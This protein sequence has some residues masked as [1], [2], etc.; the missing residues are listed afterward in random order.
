MLGR[1]VCVPFFLCQPGST[2]APPSCGSGRCHT[3]PAQMLQ[4]EPQGKFGATA[5]PLLVLRCRG[6]GCAQQQGQRQGQRLRSSLLREFHST[7][8]GQFLSGLCLVAWDRPWC[9]RSS[10]PPAAGRCVGAGWLAGNFILEKRSN[11]K[12]GYMA[13]MRELRVQPRMS[14]LTKAGGRTLVVLMISVVDCM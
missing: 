7:A 14:G 11:F 8:G 10:T 5:D 4:P 9:V 13:P 3:F 6:R 12:D 2:R 1:K